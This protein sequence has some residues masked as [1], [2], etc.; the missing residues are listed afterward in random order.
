MFLFHVLYHQSG[1]ILVVVVH[2]DMNLE[3]R[4]PGVS[5]RGLRIFA[6]NLEA[7]RVHLFDNLASH[8][9]VVDFGQPA[10]LW[11]ETRVVELLERRRG[12]VVPQ[13]VYCCQARKVD[14][15]A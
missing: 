1:K 14:P 9:Q 7:L 6:C 2:L 10:L 12:G 4:A 11:L 3:L 15:C 8:L 5:E 13:V